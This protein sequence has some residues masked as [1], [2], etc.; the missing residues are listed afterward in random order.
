MHKNFRFVHTNT[1]CKY[2]KNYAHRLACILFLLLWRVFCGLF[3][4][5]DD[6]AFVSTNIFG[7]KYMMSFSEQH[8]ERFEVLFNLRKSKLI[9]MS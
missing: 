4:F 8:A 9:A 6:L 5:A 2:R 1:F 7:L 3:G